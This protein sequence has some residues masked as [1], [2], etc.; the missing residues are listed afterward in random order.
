MSLD[1][2]E[3]ID[4]SIF[5]FGSFQRSLTQSII[6]LVI[7]ISYMNIKINIIDVG[8]NIGDKSLTITRFLLNLRIRNFKIFSIEPTEFAYKKQ[9]KN[10]RNN[11]KLKKKISLFNHF[12]TNKKKRVNQIYSSWNLKNHSDNHKIHGGILKNI[13]QQTKHLSLDNFVKMN[14]IK[15]NIILKI[16]VDGFELNVLKSAKKLL[17][18][19]NFVIYMEYAPYAF[20]DHGT[21]AQ[22][23][24]KFVKK[25][26]LNIYDLNYRRLKNIKIVE[27]QSTDIVLIKRIL[28]SFKCKIYNIF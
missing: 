10:I 16:D 1:L 2:S 7:K 12:I 11:P 3:V 20:K 15:E 8:S 24:F 27:G 26:K 23:F 18:R 6:S 19:D 13:N 14:N 22:E 5:L 9:L 25:F 4:L 17:K 28:N 21:S